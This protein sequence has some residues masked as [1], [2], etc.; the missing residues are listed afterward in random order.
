[1][2]K[3][4]FVMFIRFYCA[5]LLYLLLFSFNARTQEGAKPFVVTESA[6]T[7]ETT[8]ISSTGLWMWWIAVFKNPNPDYY[9]AHPQVTVVARN[10]EGQVKG[11]YDKSM[12]A[13]FTPSGTIAYGDNLEVLEVP[14]KLE[15]IP[16][17]CYWTKLTT[18]VKPLPEFQA[19]NV[20]LI[21]T[22]YRLKVAGEVINP[23]AQD[24]DS[25]MGA[26][27][28]RDQAGKLLGGDLF[29]I[30]NI[31][32]QATKPFMDDLYDQG[33]IPRKYNKFEF[34]VFPTSLINYNQLLQP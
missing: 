33:A 8:S 15:I 32:A 5:A 6:F 1:M 30:K 7:V 14:A 10:R 29:Y 31:P 17:K 9:C 11:T 27:L 13:F 22:Q 26:V 28:F 34:M 23:L 4:G 3:K 21:P 12:V 24:I 19:R 2:R 20:R 18:G 16:A 25:V